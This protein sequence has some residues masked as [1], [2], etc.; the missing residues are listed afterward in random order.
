MS[1][2]SFSFQSTLTISPPSAWGDQN[3]F[4]IEKHLFHCFL[5]FSYISSIV[6]RKFIVTAC[7]LFTLRF[8]FFSTTNIFVLYIYMQNISFQFLKILYYNKLL[9]FLLLTVNNKWAIIWIWISQCT[10]TNIISDG[11]PALHYLGSPP[12]PLFFPD[13]GKLLILGLPLLLINS[14]DCSCLR[15]KNKAV[16]P[17]T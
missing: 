2:F 11:F 14:S 16:C 5:Y 13:F 6:I 15:W 7:W 4:T 9:Q 8:E 3:S 12:F 17:Q 1:S 10:H